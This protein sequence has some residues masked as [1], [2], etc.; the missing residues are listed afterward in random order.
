MTSNTATKTLNKDS[1]ITYAGPISWSGTSFSGTNSQTGL[2]I[3]GSVSAD[4]KT[5]SPVIRSAGGGTILTLNGVPIR[6]LGEAGSFNSSFGGNLSGPSA[7]KVEEVFV[8]SS[9]N[10]WQLT[11]MDTSNKD[12]WL[13]ANVQFSA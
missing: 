11:G 8:D 1:S 2:S 12:N 10:K 3:S 13:M 5:A 4:V 7:G 6:L 9:N